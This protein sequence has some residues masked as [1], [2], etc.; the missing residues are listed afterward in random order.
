ML[1]HTH[2]YAHDDGH[3]QPQDFNLAT[4]AASFR[5][6]ALSVCSK[7]VFFQDTK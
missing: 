3:P 6:L 2:A 5:G 4:A 7:Q 1:L